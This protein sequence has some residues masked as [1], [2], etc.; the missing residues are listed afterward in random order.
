MKEKIQEFLSKIHISGIFNK[1]KTEKLKTGISRVTKKIFRNKR[2]RLIAYGAVFLLLVLLLIS[3]FGGKKVKLDKYVTVSFSGNSGSGT[4]S[5]VIDRNAFASDYRKKDINDYTIELDKT[6]GLSNGDTVTLTLDK[7]KKT[8]TVSGLREIIES[9][10]QISQE[11]LEKVD[12]AVLEEIGKDYEGDKEVLGHIFF[13]NRIHTLVNTY[14]RSQEVFLLYEVN[15][16]EADLDNITFSLGSYIG[17]RVMLI[18]G[19]IVDAYLDEEDAIYEEESLLLE[20]EGKA[21]YL[22]GA[23]VSVDVPLGTVK[24][25]VDKLNI[26]NEPSLQGT[27]RSTTQTGR[28]YPVYEIVHADGYDWYRIGKNK[29]IAS[30]EEEWTTYTEANAASEG[31]D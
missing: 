1:E 12:Q 23:N 20:E 24:I 6:S 4:A 14:V 18:D 28:I 25:L 22:E 7:K 31:N 29:F 11:Q 17:D 26:R 15:E 5:I 8:I 9:L 30:K 16:V 10:D 21:V 27:I 19:R 13:K 2:N 3:L